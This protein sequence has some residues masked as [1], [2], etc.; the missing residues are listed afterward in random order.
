M[1]AVLRESDSPV[2]S[3]ET[4]CR[5]VLFLFLLSRMAKLCV[6]GEDVEIAC[7]NIGGD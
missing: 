2:V 5:F 7:N 6:V 1:A 4:V 3:R